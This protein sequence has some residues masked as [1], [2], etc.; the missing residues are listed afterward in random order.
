MS[1]IFTGSKFGFSRPII[2]TVSSEDPVS[3]LLHFDGADFSTTF[4][5]SSR[6]NL[7]VTSDNGATIRTE[8]AKFGNASV[9]FGGTSWL[10]SNYNS[11]LDLNTND[12]TVE[13]WIFPFSFSSRPSGQTIS[14]SCGGSYTGFNATNGIHW[15]LELT[16]TGN[17]QLRIRTSSGSAQLTTTGGVSENVW[18]H[19]AVSVVGATAYLG[20]NGTVQSGAIGTV[21]RPTT[22]PTF[23]IANIFGRPNSQSLN[24]FGAMD[25]MRVLKG[26]GLY[27][28]NYNVPTSAFSVT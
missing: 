5:D 3:L 1:P 15:V 24:F 16:P 21:S 6:Y 20:I 12:F 26:L 11:V 22:N 25:E 19:V 28:A 14:S 23:G 27:T 7:T 18:T 13:V 10:Y 9:R 4:T 2:T 8:R 17:L